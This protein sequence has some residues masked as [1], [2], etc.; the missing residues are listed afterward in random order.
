M[1]EFFGLALNRFDDLGVTV[2]GRGDRDTR[3]PIYIPVPVY[4][5]YFGAAPAVHHKR[6]VAGVRRGNH[7]FVSLEQF[8]RLGTRRRGNDPRA[9]RPPAS[10]RCGLILHNESRSAG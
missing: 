5:P 3:R 7:L 1:Y 10:V 6:I 8:A 9:A 4:V 2:P